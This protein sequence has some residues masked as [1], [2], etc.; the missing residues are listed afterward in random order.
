MFADEP[1]APQSLG[2]P[3]LALSP[4]EAA[5]SIGVGRTLFYETVLPELPVVRAGRRRI[6][7]VEALR[8]W[9]KTH[10]ARWDD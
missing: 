10:S 9:L 6:I 2:V 3:R 7:E 4:G 8:E 5:K 1:I